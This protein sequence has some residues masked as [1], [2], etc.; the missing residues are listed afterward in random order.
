MDNGQITVIMGVELYFKCDAFAEENCKVLM[1]FQT[2]EN[3]QNADFAL[4]YE[5]L[6]IFVDLVQD[7]P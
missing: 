3:L 5:S 7:L 4:L 6:D 2:P 1:K